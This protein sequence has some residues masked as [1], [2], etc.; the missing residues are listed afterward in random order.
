MTAGFVSALQQHRSFGAT[1]ERYKHAL[2]SLDSAFPDESVPVEDKLTFLVTNHPLL[3][4]QAAL[5]ITLIVAFSLAKSA[6]LPSKVISSVMDQI[7]ICAIL[8]SGLDVF[9]SLRSILSDANENSKDEGTFSD[10]MKDGVLRLLS[11][12]S[13]LVISHCVLGLLYLR[14]LHFVDVSLIPFTIPYLALSIIMLAYVVHPSSTRSFI[15]KYNVFNSPWSGTKCTATDSG[16]KQQR[17][18]MDDEGG[19]SNEAD[20]GNNVDNN[21]LTENNAAA[22][23]SISTDGNQ[24]KKLPEKKTKKKKKKKKVK[25]TTTKDERTVQTNTFAKILQTPLYSLHGLCDI[26]MVALEALFYYKLVVF[27]QSNTAA[28]AWTMSLDSL[29]IVLSMLYLFRRIQSIGAGPGGVR[30]VLNMF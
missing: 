20:A 23:N 7:F 22:T 8:V 17:S 12:Q 25:T 1:L 5:A 18:S 30:G 26:A 24:V 11:D 29:R 27:G 4:I 16:A 10:I 28:N 15:S 19:K 6:R 9:S 2:S 13:S 3:T 21:P 14:K